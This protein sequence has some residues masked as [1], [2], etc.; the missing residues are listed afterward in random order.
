MKFNSALN[1]GDTG[2]V[3]Y[4][5]QVKGITVGQIQIIYTESKEIDEIEFIG[6]I[7]CNAGENFGK[8]DKTYREIYMCAETGIGSG[9]IWELGVS[10][11]ATRE[12][13]EVAS[14]EKIK[15]ENEEKRI[16]VQRSNK[17]LFDELSYLEK[18]RREVRDQ[19]AKIPKEIA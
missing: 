13:C 16:R 8:F 14:A 7:R 11:F 4:N 5:G 3:F 2:Y 12:E 19:I 9:S 18:R 15:A 17:A 10:I 1:C 6:S